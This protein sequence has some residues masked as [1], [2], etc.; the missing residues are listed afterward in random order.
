MIK[1]PEIK[2]IATHLVVFVLG[3][4]SVYIYFYSHPEVGFHPQQRHPGPMVETIRASLTKELQ[5]TPDQVAKLDPILNDLGAQMEVLRKN[6]R[7][8]AETVFSTA[9]A[10]IATILT[11]DQQETFKKIEAEQKGRHHF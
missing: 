6:M 1:L 11:P 5:L 10:K 3:A 7:G 8:E 9:N 4:L 2:L